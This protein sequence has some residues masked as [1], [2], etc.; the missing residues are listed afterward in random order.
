MEVEIDKKTK[1]EIKKT[2]KKILKDCS[3]NTMT[4]KSVREKASAE[5]DLDIDLN[6]AS[7]KPIVSDCVEEFL[8][9]AKAE[10]EEKRAQLQRPN[11][12]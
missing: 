7:Y 9:K 2:V 12:T 11:T 5:L 10:S 8:V 3:L 4:E 6:D 1:R